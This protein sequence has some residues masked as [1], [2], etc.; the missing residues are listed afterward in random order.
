[1]IKL[2]KLRAL[3][4]F[5]GI[6]VLIWSVMCISSIRTCI[7]I[8]NP[9]LVNAKDSWALRSGNIV[10]VEY[11]YIFEEG[12]R[13][14]FALGRNHYYE[15]IKIKDK[16]EFVFGTLKENY[17]SYL[18]GK[19]YFTW[20]DDVKEYECK[21]SCI[22]LGKVMKITERVEKILERHNVKT[23]DT[24][25]K[26]PNTVTNT[27]YDYYIQYIEP[28]DEV[29]RLLGRV[30]FWGILI[31]LWFVLFKKLRREREAYQFFL[32]EE[33]AKERQRI[34]MSIEQQRKEAARQQE[35]VYWDDF[36][37]I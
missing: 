29:D 28:E 35:Q 21:E 7:G 22:F 27:N 37:D 1:M 11:D 20:F 10:C 13:T 3:L 8:K 4:V 14:G 15:I 2:I 5:I 12:Y 36:D 23:E 31:A 33:R 30:T 18:E 6:F 19:P 17:L 26:H 25:Y 9:K 24:I 32:N 34:Q 16:D